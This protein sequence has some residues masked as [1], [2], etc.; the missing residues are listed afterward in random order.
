MIR[1]VIKNRMSTRY[2][3]EEGSRTLEV[4]IIHIWPACINGVIDD[5]FRIGNAAL[6]LETEA[7]AVE[8]AGSILTLHTC[9]M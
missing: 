1:L 9:I 3:M 8:H 4:L 2:S 5:V 7:M 6:W